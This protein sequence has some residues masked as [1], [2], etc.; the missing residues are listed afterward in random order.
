MKNSLS[1]SS[2]TQP[3]TSWREGSGAVYLALLLVQIFFGL[4]YFAAKIVLAEI[5]A[6][7]WAAIRVT[8][9]AIIMLLLCVPRARKAFPRSARDIGALFIYSVFGVM[10]NQVCFT[11]GLARTTPT[12]SAIINSSIPVATLLFA[13]LL[14]K[15]RYSLGKL[16]S[17]TISLSGVLYLLKIEQF[18]LNDAQMVGDLLTFTNAMS[19]SLFLVISKE[20]VMRYDSFVTTAILLAFGSLGISS[21]SYR[22]LL[23]FDHTKVSSSV[24]LF[25]LFIVIFPTVLAYFFNYWALKRVESSLVAFFIYIQPPLAATLSIAFRNEKLTLRMVISA[26]LIFTGF[27][28]STQVRRTS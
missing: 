19:F 11:E 9:A 26:V 18:Q 28:L 1:E 17:I 27:F 6:P 4:H 21:Y 13:I 7:A 14:G 20:L 25:A 16:I 8:C 5:S 22:A 3:E 15:E 12:H 24:W 2:Y 10:I 23:D